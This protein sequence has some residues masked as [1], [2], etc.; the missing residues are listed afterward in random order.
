MVATDHGQVLVLAQKL[1]G[2]VL[3]PELDTVIHLHQLMAEEIAMY[4]DRPVNR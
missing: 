4:S 3:K 1:V 2:K